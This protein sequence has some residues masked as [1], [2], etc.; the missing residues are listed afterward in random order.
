MKKCKSCDLEELVKNGRP[1]GVQRY[2]CKSCGREQIDGDKRVKFPNH[3]KKSAVVMYLEGNGL[4]AIARILSSIFGVKIYFQTV[5]K[6]LKQAGDI[7]EKEVAKVNES[8][9]LKKIDLVEMDELYTYI[10]KNKIK[11]E[12]GLL[13]IGMHSVYLN[14]K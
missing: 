4:R 3:I 2:L 13:L 6:W 14:L 7:V 11:S 9:E 12:S 8:T 5:A 1:K 10:K